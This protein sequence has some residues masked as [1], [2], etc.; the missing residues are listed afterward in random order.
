MEH[1]FPEMTIPSA[2]YWD[3]TMAWSTDDSIVLWDNSKEIEMEALFS[4]DSVWDRS[5]ELRLA[6]LK[7]K[8]T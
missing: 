8:L 1:H 7:V 6:P 4:L 5:T 2:H 3:S